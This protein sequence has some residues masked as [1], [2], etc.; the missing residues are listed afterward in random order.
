MLNTATVCCTLLLRSRT[1][2][3]WQIVLIA[4][5]LFASCRLA[6][7][8]WTPAIACAS[9]GFMVGFLFLFSVCFGVGGAEPWKSYRF[10]QIYSTIVVIEARNRCQDA[11][12]IEPYGFQ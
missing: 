12:P 11:V 7:A 6:R 8:L 5:L 4:T 1:L 9:T 10:R 3:E 2:T